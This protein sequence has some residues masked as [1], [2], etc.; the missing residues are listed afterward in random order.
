MPIHILDEGRKE[1][2]GR[3]DGQTD[4]QIGPTADP[5]LDFLDIGSLS[6]LA[7]SVRSSS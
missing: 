4:V 2:D 1:E 7:R 6:L 5:I 3:T